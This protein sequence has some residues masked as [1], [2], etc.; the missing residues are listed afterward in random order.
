LEGNSVHFREII[1]GERLRLDRAPLQKY[2]KE[3]LESSAR[4]WHDKRKEES[5]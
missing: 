3:D 1:R 2:E 4:G 5:A